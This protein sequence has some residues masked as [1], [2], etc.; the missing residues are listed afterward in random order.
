MA[1]VDNHNLLMS[2]MRRVP[3]NDDQSMKATGLILMKMIQS[4][5]GNKLTD[6]AAGSLVESYIDAVEDLPSW[7]VAAAIKRWNRGECGER[8]YRWRPAPAELRGI[9]REEAWKVEGRARMLMNLATSLPIQE[10][11]EEH[12]AGM[13]ERLARLLKSI[14]GK[15]DVVDRM[16]RENRERQERELEI[17]KARAI[18][19]L[20]E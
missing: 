11:S 6:A 8:D 3:V 14:I 12:C 20:G 1:L 15:E 13:M 18:A 4:L 10:Y 19:E 2:F 9:A 16:R 5:S 7:A 17:G